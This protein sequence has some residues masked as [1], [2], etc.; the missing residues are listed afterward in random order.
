MWLHKV[1]GQQREVHTA[2]QRN[3]QA[4]GNWKHGWKA[5]LAR[6]AAAATS[7]APAA[8]F[9]LVGNSAGFCSSTVSPPGSMMRQGTVGAVTITLAPCS[10]SSR[11]RNTCRWEGRNDPLM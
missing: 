5:A 1:A 7:C 9:V 3:K 4:I 6:A 2:A 8:I 10:C 11:W